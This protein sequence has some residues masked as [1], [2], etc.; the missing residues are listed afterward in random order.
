MSSDQQ[1]NAE[2]TD[3]PLK[4]TRMNNA[5]KKPHSSSK[6]RRSSFYAEGS[7]RKPNRQRRKYSVTARRAL[8]AVSVLLLL[9]AVVFAAGCQWGSKDISPPVEPPDSFSSSGDA[10]VPD[11][12]WTAFD[13]QGLN[14]IVDRALT[15]NFS[16]KTAWQRL[17]AAQAAVDQETAALFPHVDVF[18]QGEVNR[19]DG[20]TT[21]S[22][23]VGATATY[24]LDLWG[25]IQSRI[26]A[27]RYRRKASLQD[28]QAAA[29]SLSAEIARTAFRLTAARKRVRIL[30]EQI[31]TNKDILE[32]L[33]S[34]FA[35]GQTRRADVLRQRQLVKSTR[36]QKAVT[37]ATIGVLEHQLAV[38]MGQP[39]QQAVEYHPQS[40]PDL[41][42]LPDAGVPVKLVHRRPDVRAAYNRVRAAD[43]DLAVAVTQQ[44][45]RLTFDVSLASR[46]DTANQLFENWAR[47]FAADITAPLLD[48][49]ERKAQ[50][51]RRRA[52]KKQR[53]YEYGDTIL[54]A[55]REVEDALIEE[56][57]QKQQIQ[58]LEERVRIAD[59]TY[60]QLRR[61]YING[62]SDFSEMLNALDDQQAL[63][64]DLVSAKLKL[65]EFRIAL[66]RALAGGFE[67]ARQT[68]SDET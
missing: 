57:R 65:M 2:N 29:L 5:N 18:G 1:S 55:F 43:Q 58:D 51:A 45:P 41:P 26:E 3:R 33:E 6:T 54:T 46:E 53:L 35:N 36:Q 32:L 11:R 7:G 34:R 68:G 21:E 66:Y 31:S 23:R 9:I 4:A 22:L 19:T 28:Y 40:L 67:T 39:P 49:G 63:R 64:R 47:S 10:A 44:Y 56:D 52:Q 42:A 20:E 24:E 13:H 50:V 38:L 12:W 61:E 8:P 15:S 17:Q 37:G 62:V 16:L 25:K 27:E 59:E 30:N 48:A 60:Q 14:T